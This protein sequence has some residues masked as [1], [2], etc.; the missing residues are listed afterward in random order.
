MRFSSDLMD[1]MDYEWDIPPDNLIQ[2]LNITIEIVSLPIQTG[3]VPYMDELP[4]G[5]L[6][7]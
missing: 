5:Y 2:L 3:D 4:S 6:S 7:Y 1:L